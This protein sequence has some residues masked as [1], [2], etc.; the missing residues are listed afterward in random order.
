MSVEPRHDGR[1]G[2]PAAEPDTCGSAE[3]PPAMDMTCSRVPLVNIRA[4]DFG[5]CIASISPERC[6]EFGTVSLSAAV[7]RGQ[8]VLPAKMLAGGDQE[9]PA[10]ATELHQSS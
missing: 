3:P 4:A 8:V 9:D 6:G 2:S 7:I 10:T 5:S 1:D